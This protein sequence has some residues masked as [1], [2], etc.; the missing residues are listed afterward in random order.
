MGQQRLGPFDFSAH[1]LSKRVLPDDDGSGDFPDGE[2]MYRRL[3]YKAHYE[4]RC[5]GAETHKT[6]APA[7]PDG[8][9]LD[10]NRLSWRDLRKAMVN[11]E[12]FA[13]VYQQ[14]D[15]A[16]LDALVQRIWV[17]GGR[18]SDG[19]SYIGCWDNDRDAW[20]LPSG[21][22][23]MHNLFGD[24]LGIITV[25]P[26]AAKYWSV[27]AW[28]VHPSSEQRFLLDLYRARMEAPDFLD[29]S[30]NLNRFTGL[31]EDWWHNFARIGV[32]LTHVIVEVNAA[33]R[34][35]LQYDFFHRWIRQRSVSILAHSTQRNK[36][37]ADFGVQMLAPKWEH[38][39]V[40]LPGK[41]AG[42]ISAMRLV[43]EVLRWPNST[44]S[45]CVMAQ[46]FLEHNLDKIYTPIEDT[47]IQKWRPSWLVAG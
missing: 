40:R 43:D 2:P 46:W 15:R 25:D 42:R 22:D 17:D 24:V 27:Q 38:G 32:P 35:M 16:T 41:G 6:G 14:E 28:A 12:K 1:I 23:G 7:W 13:V 21:P 11:K 8:C 37:D 10:P 39:Q 34:Y 47:V 19:R 45:D 31:A 18:D 5:L 26:S 29:W 44:T 9:L 3:L 33:Q 36:A 4:D 30:S 20:Q